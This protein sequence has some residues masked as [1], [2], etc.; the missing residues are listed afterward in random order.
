[1]AVVPE[2]PKPIPALGELIGGVVGLIVTP[3][4]LLEPDVPV[5]APLF[6]GELRRHGWGRRRIGTGYC[7]SRSTIVDLQSQFA[8]SRR[9]QAVLFDR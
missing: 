8:W 9:V 4:E 3:V 5:L 1:M 7:G 2:I 6:E